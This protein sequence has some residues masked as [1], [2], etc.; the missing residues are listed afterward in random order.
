[1]GMSETAWMDDRE[2]RCRCGQMGVV[3]GVEGA[4]AH[5]DNVWVTHQ[6]GLS[7]Q[8]HIHR[9]PQMPALLAQRARRA[10]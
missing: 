6:V 3:T 8:T 1:V 4:E 5:P 7:L 2:I 10:R 9:A